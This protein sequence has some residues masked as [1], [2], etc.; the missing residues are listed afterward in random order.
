MLQYIRDEIKVQQ[1]VDVNIHHVNIHHLYVIFGKSLYSERLIINK[2][3]YVHTILTW[4]N[5]VATINH[6]CKMTVSV[7]SPERLSFEG[8][9]YCNVIMIAA[10]TV[11]KSGI[12]MVQI[13]LIF[14]F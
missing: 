5:V 6:L 12:F 1:T 8:S 4:L 11:Q 14:L 13:I 2:Q 7:I 10:A 9:V 3:M